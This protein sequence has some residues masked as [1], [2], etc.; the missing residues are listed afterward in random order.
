[1]SGEEAAT[2]RPRR[3]TPGGGLEEIDPAAEARA[4]EERAASQA[5]HAE[6]VASR[7]AEIEA[8]RANEAAADPGAIAAQ[9]I[10][11]LADIGAILSEQLALMREAAERQAA[12]AAS[13]EMLRDH[14]DPPASP[15]T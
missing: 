10:M 6:Q 11:I 5:R 8:Q 2:P 15:S 13:L 12:M 3:I 9:V 7:V 1:V 4:A 14:L